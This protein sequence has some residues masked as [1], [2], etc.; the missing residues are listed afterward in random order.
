[1]EKI[2]L[3]VDRETE[4]VINSFSSAFDLWKFIK[5]QEKRFCKFFLPVHCV[6]KAGNEYKKYNYKLVEKSL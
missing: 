3:I 2:Y 4:K 6:S 1:M 5:D